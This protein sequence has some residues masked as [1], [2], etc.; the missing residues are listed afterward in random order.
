MSPQLVRI[1]FAIVLLGHGLGH[2][3][4]AFPLFGIRLSGSHSTESWA[5][6]RVLADGPVSGLCV[7]VNLLALLAFVGAGLAVAGW[8]V[9]RGAWER[10]ALLGGIVSCLGL[11]LFWDAFP[12]LFPNKIGVMVVNVWAISSVL[13]LR[14]PAGLFDG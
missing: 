8:G 7:A 10:M 4:A 9:P 11:V 13:W 1:A 5:L 12:F 6:G 14:W 2:A 3:L